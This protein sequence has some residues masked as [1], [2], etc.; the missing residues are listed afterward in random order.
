MKNN[1]GFFIGLFLIVSC[2]E[3][4]RADHGNLSNVSSW[5]NGL[6]ASTLTGGAS[7]ST[8]SLSADHQENH[9]MIIRA[10]ERDAL[11]VLNGESPTDLFLQAKRSLEFLSQEESQEIVSFDNDHAA[12]KIIEFCQN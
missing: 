7:S 3:N 9:K 10:A 2:I 6:G 11:V 12:L 1:F 4:A 5:G 8:A